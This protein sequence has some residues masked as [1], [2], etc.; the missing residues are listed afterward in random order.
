ML[1]FGAGLRAR[2]IDRARWSWFEFDVKGS[3]L[4]S[5]REEAEFKPKGGSLR[6]IR[7]PNELYEALVATRT[8]LSSPYVLG[9]QAGTPE[10]EARGEY[11]LPQVFRAASLWLRA[12]GVEKGDSGNPLHRLRKQ[13]GSEL[14]TEFGLFAAQKLL[15][16]SSPAVTSKYYA[17]QTELPDL[18]HVRVMG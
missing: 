15:G 1:A 12:R 4:L 18:T 2:E 10:A 6:I 8:D 13:F 16:H 9:G 7:V 3:C 5:V 17:A 11:R 14:A